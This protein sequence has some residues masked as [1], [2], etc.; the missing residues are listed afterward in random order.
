[1]SLPVHVVNGKQPLR[2][3][4]NRW[5]SRSQNAACYTLRKL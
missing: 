2:E 3:Q 1:M 4:D 5:Q